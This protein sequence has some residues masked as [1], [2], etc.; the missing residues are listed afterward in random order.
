MVVGLG[1]VGGETSHPSTRRPSCS[2]GRYEDP[3]AVRRFRQSTRFPEAPRPPAIRSDRV[4]VDFVACLR[5]AT[6]D[7][8]ESTRTT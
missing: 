1:E 4:V 7:E 3:V 6:S 5:R 2:G 8:F